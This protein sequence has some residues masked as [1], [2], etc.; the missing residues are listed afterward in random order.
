MGTSSTVSDVFAMQSD[1]PKDHDPD[2]VD[3]PFYIHFDSSQVVCSLLVAV[4]L[5][6]R[7]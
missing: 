4:L 7:F 5:S 6:C 3:L 1:E 2:C